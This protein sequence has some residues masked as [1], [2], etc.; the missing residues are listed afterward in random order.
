MTYHIFIILLCGVVVLLIYKMLYLKKQLQHK[1]REIKDITSFSESIF[2]NIQAYVLLINPDFIVLK[3][4]FYALT[5]TQ[6]SSP[7]R[8]GELF[9]CVNAIEA[10]ECGKG[11]LCKTCIIRQT[12]TNSLRHKSNFS[13]LEATLQIQISDK[14]VHSCHVLI[15]GSYM[16]TQPSG[17]MLLTI[18]DITDQKQNEL[19]LEDIKEKFK[20]VERSKSLFLSNLGHKIRNQLNG[21]LGWTSLVIADQKLT[22]TQQQEY[23]NL[24]Y[25]NTDNLLHLSDNIIQ[26]SQVD[27]VDIDISPSVFNV[28]EL[29]QN[30]I[31]IRLSYSHPNVILYLDK[32][33]EDI[34]VYSDQMKLH[35]IL[36][37]IISNAQRF[38]NKG[39]IRIACQ[40]NKKQHSVDFVVEDTGCGMSEE[41]QIHLFE[42]FYRGND[43]SDSPGLGLSIC[44]A[45]IKALGGD[46]RVQSK[47]D[48]G[49]SVFFSIKKNDIPKE[50]LIL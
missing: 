8:V 14:K 36:L 43:F 4:N 9:N 37:N 1:I 2:E 22:S 24:I 26:F 29:C 7:K 34:I 17:G 5:S 30:L 25:Q 40:I 33:V 19:R 35:Q 13:K 27:N 21:I 32:T 42:R 45:Y 15:Y 28:K 31:N 16:Y 39:F 12:I 3:T 49:T 11:E 44:Q 41:Q 18:C 50:E 20:R 10:G 48:R 23:I 6:A 47:K 38:T 46:I